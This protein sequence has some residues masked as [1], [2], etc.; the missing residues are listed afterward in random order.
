M[1]GFERYKIEV[2]GLTGNPSSL[3]FWFTAPRDTYQ[4][5]TA[6]ETGVEK[7]TVTGS[8]NSVDETA[9]LCT[10]EALLKSGYALRKKIVYTTGSGVSLRRKYASIIIAKNKAATFAPSGTFRGG[11]IRRVVNPTDAVFS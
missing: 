2:G 5:L 8:E 11:T 9:P 6:S 1:A 7:V 3:T 4:G 10:V